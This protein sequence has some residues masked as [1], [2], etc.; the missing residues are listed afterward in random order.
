MFRS[1]ELIRM[2]TNLAALLRIELRLS[3]SEPEIPTMETG[4]QIGAGN[5][6]RTDTSDLEGRHASR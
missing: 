6:I 4:H 3:G 5:R 1:Y 2:V